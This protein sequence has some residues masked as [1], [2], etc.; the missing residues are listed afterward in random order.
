[1]QDNKK[2]IIDLI[3]NEGGQTEEE[4]MAIVREV[5][6]EENMTEEQVMKAIEEL[7]Q[8]K[9]VVARKQRH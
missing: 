5:A 4:F 8:F 7:R 6:E 2:D 3:I 1:M 9:F